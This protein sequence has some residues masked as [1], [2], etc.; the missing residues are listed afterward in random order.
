MVLVGRLSLPPGLCATWASCHLG[1]VRTVCIL[2]GRDK[3]LRFACKYSFVI[4]ELWS[5]V[6]F[7]CSRFVLGLAVVMVLGLCFCVIR[8]C[9]VLTTQESPLS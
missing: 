2:V 6:L 1:P 5:Q 3:T 7:I 4:R 8:V 9:S